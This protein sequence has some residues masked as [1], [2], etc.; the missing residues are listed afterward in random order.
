VEV[1]NSLTIDGEIV[2]ETRNG[3]DSDYIPDPLGS[4]AHIVAEG[5]VITDSFTY[6]P[7]GEVRTHTGTNP[8]PFQ[9]GGTLGYYSDP[10]G[11]IYVRERELDAPLKGWLTV[12]P[13]WPNELPYGYVGGNPVSYTD[14]TGLGCSFKVAVCGQSAGPRCASVEVRRKK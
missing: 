7:Y 2:S 9:F 5:G 10:W 1:V 4:V 12:D 13:L 6:W 8:T 11:G 3:I 14:P